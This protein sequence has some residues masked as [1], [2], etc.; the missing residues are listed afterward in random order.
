MSFKA[1]FLCKLFSRGLSESLGSPEPPL[2][3]DE[4]SGGAWSFHSQSPMWLGS[5]SVLSRTA[6]TCGAGRKRLLWKE[7]AKISS[8]FSVKFPRLIQKAKVALNPLL[9]GSAVPSRFHPAS[10]QTSFPS[11]L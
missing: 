8:H 6:P 4:R 1:P 10:I 5:I 7:A 3:A 11:C 2:R 9:F